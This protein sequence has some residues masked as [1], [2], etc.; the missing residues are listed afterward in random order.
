M[1]VQFV[2]SLWFF[3]QSAYLFKFGVATKTQNR[4]EA[5]PGCRLV[6]VCGRGPRRRAWPWPLVLANSTSLCWSCFSWRLHLKEALQGTSMIVK[7][8]SS[9]ISG[10]HVRGHV[11]LASQRLAHW[12]PY[13]VLLLSDHM[14]FPQNVLYQQVFQFPY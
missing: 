9:C 3:Y 7:L 11:W 5:S 8:S 4:G 2:L 12:W 10:Q 6:P 1:R 14:Q 13:L